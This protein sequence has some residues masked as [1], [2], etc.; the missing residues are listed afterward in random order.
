MSV[1]HRQLYRVVFSQE[2]AVGAVRSG[3]VA[4]YRLLYHGLPYVLTKK[5]LDKMMETDEQAVAEPL[6]D[7]PLTE[8]SQS[9][10]VFFPGGIGDVIA[11]KAVLEDLHQ[12]RPWLNITVASTVADQWIIGDVATVLDY[13]VTETV[14]KGFDAWVNVAEMDFS[15]VG[16]ELVETFAQYVGIPCPD[17]A[18]NIEPY[19]GYMEA[20][21][22]YIRNW[23]K[24]R[25]GIHLASASHWRSIPNFVGLYVAM[26]MADRGY[27]VYLLGGPED[28]IVFTDNEEHSDPPDN[29][30]DMTQVLGPLEYYLGFLPSLDVLLTCD[31]GPM[32][33][34]GAMNIPTLALFGMT[35]G[36][37]RTGY[38]PSV[39]YIQ[40]DM[41]CSPCERIAEVAPC[42]GQ[43]C[44]AL[45][46]MNPLYIADQLEEVYRE[47]HDA[48][49]LA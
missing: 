17:H 1:P 43:W 18:P 48:D 34:A 36:E 5:Y 30:Y 23:D 3:V 9:L 37:K 21:E 8:T 4:G 2:L 31:S 40:S 13:P 46:R 6:P 15:S 16:R 14:A 33:M 24:P 25:V 41:E 11:L 49:C 32:H 44:E 19:Y 27:D 7:R 47:N 10:L 12:L 45:A 26:E 22:H 20:M 39:R 42:D 28:R 38:Y 35:N 29:I